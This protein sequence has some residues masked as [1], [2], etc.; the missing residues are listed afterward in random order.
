[1]ATTAV[2]IGAMTTSVV[3]ISKVTEVAQCATTS[4]RVVDQR[5]MALIPVPADVSPET[6]DGYRPSADKVLFLLEI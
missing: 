2:V 5:H 4:I 3:V 6:Q 1:V